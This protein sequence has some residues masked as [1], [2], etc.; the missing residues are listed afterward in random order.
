MSYVYLWRHPV[1]CTMDRL[2][3]VRTIAG[4]VAETAET[5]SAS[6]VYQLNNASGH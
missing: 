2:Q 1:W 4:S 3:E 5:S 6:K